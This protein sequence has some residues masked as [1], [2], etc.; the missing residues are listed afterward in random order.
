M[1]KK[2]K[3]KSIE[4]MSEPNFIKPMIVEFERDGQIQYW[5]IVKTHNSVHILVDNIETKELLFVK[6]I[7]IP[8]LVNNPE[9]TGE[10]IECCAGLVDKEKSL[11]EIAKE[12]VLEEMGYD[13]P[14]GNFLSIRENKSSVGTKGSS[15]Q[16]YSVQVD[17]SM[18]VSEGG[19][20]EDED[21]EV[22]RIPY[23]DVLNLVYSR[24]EYKET[25]TDSTT[26]FQVLDWFVSTNQE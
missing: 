18:K 2:V 15:V 10:V 8:V 9:G 16:C 4:P 12:E 20:L 19:G 17:E 23:K 5:E 21:I 6:Q 22:V 7:R 13:V 1:L 3:I 11:V 26:M 25:M 14:L 24:G